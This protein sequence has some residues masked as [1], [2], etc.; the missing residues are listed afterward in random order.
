MKINPIQQNN[1]SHKAYFKPNENFR[2][3]F[4]HQIMVKHC[5]ESLLKKFRNM[6]NHEI[7]IVDIINTG[8]NLAYGDFTCTLINNSTKKTINLFIEKTYHK[9]DRLLEELTRDNHSW[10]NQFYE[11]DD[12]NIDDYMNLTKPR[13]RREI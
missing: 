5:E 4:G 12:K 2:K 3:L 13:Q 11:K 10:I 7:E 9:M 8:K 6:P 1:I